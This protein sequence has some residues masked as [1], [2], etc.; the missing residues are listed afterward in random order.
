VNHAAS[1]RNFEDFY[2]FSRAGMMP[3][4]IRK[5]L[6]AAHIVCAEEFDLVNLVQ[7]VPDEWRML[8]F[9]SKSFG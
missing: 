1:L 7:S 9:G 2:I 3:L 5:Y 4:N 6:Y 8:S